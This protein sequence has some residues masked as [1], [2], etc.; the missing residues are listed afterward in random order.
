MSREEKT[1]LPNNG[2]GGL[3]EDRTQAT[4]TECGELLGGGPALLVPPLVWLRR[5]RAKK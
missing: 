4:A 2:H 3:G 1:G 5:R